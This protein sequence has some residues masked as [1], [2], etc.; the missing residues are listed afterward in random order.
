[1]TKKYSSIL[2]VWSLFLWI[3]MG[4]IAP[5]S[6]CCCRLAEV[7]LQCVLSFRR[8]WVTYPITVNG[9]WRQTCVLVP[10]W[11]NG[12]GSLRWRWER[13]EKGLAQPPTMGQVSGSSA[14]CQRHT[15][16]VYPRGSVIWWTRSNS[17]A[18]AKRLGEIT[19]LPLPRGL[20]QPLCL[21]R[22]G[23]ATCLSW[24]RKGLKVTGPQSKLTSVYWQCCRWWLLGECAKGRLPSSS[25]VWVWMVTSCHVHLLNGWHVYFFIQPTIQS[26]CI[27]IYSC[28]VTMEMHLDVWLEPQPGVTHRSFIWFDM[29]M[30]QP[31]HCSTMI[32]LLLCNAIRVLLTI[33]AGNIDYD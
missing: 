30:P 21:L 18:Q 26:D 28:M 27:K 5:C 11:I 23:K 2:F 16:R 1:M 24:S 31:S 12:P 9:N 33:V 19:H 3:W 29:T 15:L 17:F 13:G 6:V 25:P 22:L 8:H 4:D 32:W 14:R 7:T 20:G 10:K